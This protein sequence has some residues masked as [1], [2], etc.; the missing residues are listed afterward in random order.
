MKMYP[1]CKV[2][3]N[4]PKVYRELDKAYEKLSNYKQS[5]N[6]KMQI[7]AEIEAKNMEHILF[8]FQQNIDREM[9]YTSWEDSCKIKECLFGYDFR[10]GRKV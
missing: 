5:G 1:V 4:L 6:K 10:L 8:L 2:K 9:L 7:R 3:P